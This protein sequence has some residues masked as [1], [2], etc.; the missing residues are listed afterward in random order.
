M[1]AASSVFV[2][3]MVIFADD[4]AAAATQRAIEA[5]EARRRHKPEFKFSKTRADVKDSFFEAVRERPF[6]VRAIVVKKELVRS[7]ALMAGTEKLY[8]FFVDA[9]VRQNADALRDAKIVIDGFGSRASRLALKTAFRRSLPA[10]ALRS[11]EFKDSKSDVLVQLADMCAGA[12]ARAHSTDR[13]RA[14]RWL[15]V[16]R[17]SKRIDDIWEFP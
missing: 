16:L 17:K 13:T 15:K 9:L 11:V 3:A 6:S 1:E 12:I 8:E 10:S 5:S 2:V 7:S 4:S 14:D